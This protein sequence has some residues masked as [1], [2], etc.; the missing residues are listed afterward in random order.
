MYIA[1]FADIEHCVYVIKM[2]SNRLMNRLANQT[3]GIWLGGADLLV[4][5]EWI[6]VRSKEA[7]E[8]TRWAPGEPNHSRRPGN[9]ENCLDLLPHKA[10]MWNDESCERGMNFLCEAS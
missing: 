1:Y 7:L 5:N 8:Y 3:D 2:E 6:W 4:E 10:F 9:D